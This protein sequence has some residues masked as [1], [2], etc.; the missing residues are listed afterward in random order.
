[1]RG[2]EGGTLPVALRRAGV[3][4]KGGKVVVLALGHPFAKWVVERERA[5]RGTVVGSSKVRNCRM[6]LAASDVSSELLNW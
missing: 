2:K 4:S 6:V 3:G 5:I 1:M